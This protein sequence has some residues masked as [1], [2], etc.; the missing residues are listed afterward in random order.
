M[1]VKN[2]YLLPFIEAASE[3]FEA[4]CGI[5]LADEYVIEHIDGILSVGEIICLIGCSS[6]NLRGTTVF[7][8]SL[9]TAA[10]FVSAMMFEEIAED[11]PDLL[12][13]FAEILNMIAGA[14]AAKLPSDDVQITL[15]TTMLGKEQAITP[16]HSLPWTRITM[17]LPSGSEI[18]IIIS[19]EER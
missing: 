3:T 5:N 15:P 14:G 16:I 13:A 1:S 19:M 11:S 4:M 6:I 2:E 8:S 9:K 10:E 7:S 18:Q 17:T 12:D